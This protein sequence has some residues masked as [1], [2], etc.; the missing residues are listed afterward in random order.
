MSLANAQR[1]KG[2][3]PGGVGLDLRADAGMPDMAFTPEKLTGAV[4]LDGVLRAV[5]EV[6][7]M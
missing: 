1:R 4:R 6:V 7:T 5:P 2:K 3:Q